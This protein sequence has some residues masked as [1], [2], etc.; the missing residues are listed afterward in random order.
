MFSKS[1]TQRILAVLALVV[2]LTGCGSPTPAATPTVPPQPTVNVQA[3]LG[4]AQTQAVQTFVAN[5]TQNA[6]TATKIQ[7][8]NTL[9]P[10]ATL[11]PTNTP[12]PAANVPATATQRPQ[13]VGPTATVPVRCN[14]IVSSPSTDPVEPGS[15]VTVRWV[16]TN[17]GINTW[18]HDTYR[19]MYY[20]GVRFAKASNQNLAFDVPRNDDITI[21]M[22]IVAPSGAGTYNSTWAIMNGFQ[23]HCLMPLKVVVK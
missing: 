2:L 21:V 9:A 18:T 22:E 8:T 12:L 15:S 11:L 17:T 4:V 20:S 16:V 13:P 3:T 6:P 14:V 5:L 1:M 7:P 23:I 19:Y 10:T